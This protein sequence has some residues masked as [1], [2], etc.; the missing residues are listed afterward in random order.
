MEN[1]K[2]ITRRIDSI[3]FDKNE[4]KIFG[5]KSGILWANTKNSTYP[6]LYIS[7]PKNL[8]E[9]DYRYLLDKIEIEIKL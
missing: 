7:K 1:K 3:Y 6:L 8:S 9:E 2:S 4:G 5:I